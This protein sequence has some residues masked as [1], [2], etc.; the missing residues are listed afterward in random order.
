[1]C[2][3]RSQFFHTWKPWYELS[4]DWERLWEMYIA[5]LVH[6]FHLSFLRWDISL[7]LF[8]LLISSSVFC[9]RMWTFFKE[10]S[11]DKKSNKKLFQFPKLHLRQMLA[12][13]T[14]LE[15][16]LILSMFEISTRKWKMW[17]YAYRRAI[18]I[19]SKFQNSNKFLQILLN[20]FK[21]SIWIV[22]MVSAR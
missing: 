7:W 11:W 12:W 4:F 21:F 2:Q 20:D 3:T 22:H 6:F 1:M 15:V 19:T 18:Y 17:K 8:F 16:A 14:L 9:L 10:N 5:Q 13:E